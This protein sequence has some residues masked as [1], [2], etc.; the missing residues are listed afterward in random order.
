[1]LYGRDRLLSKFRYVPWS[2]RRGMKR[3]Y[4]DQREKPKFIK[5]RF[6]ACESRN[7]PLVVFIIPAVP[8]AELSPS[9]SFD[10]FEQILPERTKPTD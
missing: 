1:L 4:F 10:Y 3:K 9:S 7:S 8:M 5:V 2:I 6:L